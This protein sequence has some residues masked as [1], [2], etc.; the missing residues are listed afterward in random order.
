MQITKLILT[1]A[2]LAISVS[3]TPTDSRAKT[4]PNSLI[5]GVVQPEDDTCG[6]VCNDY[7]YD[8]GYPYWICTEGYVFRNTKFQRPLSTV[9]QKTADFVIV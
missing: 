9:I 1:I 2:A 7:C 5:I 3:A 8:G 6:G 4:S